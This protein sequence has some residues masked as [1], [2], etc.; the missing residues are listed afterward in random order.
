MKKKWL[1]WLSYICTGIILQCICIVWQVEARDCMAIGSEYLILPAM[2][3]GR[4][5]IPDMIRGMNEMMKEI[6]EEKDV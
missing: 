4:I 5:M 6:M 2:I 1:S 3:A